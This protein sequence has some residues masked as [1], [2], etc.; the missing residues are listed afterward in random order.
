MLN[1]AEGQ[2][3]VASRCSSCPVVGTA[4]ESFVETVRCGDSVFTVL[5][6]SRPHVYVFNYGVFNDAFY[7]LNSVL[8]LTTFYCL[9]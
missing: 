6:F 8:R 3:L 4:N 2:L 9:F 5:Y 7:H 1:S